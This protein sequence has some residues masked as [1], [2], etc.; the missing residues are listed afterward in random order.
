MVLR[1]VHLLSFKKGQFRRNREVNSIPKP[2]L[3]CG[4]KQLWKM[5][6]LEKLFDMSLANSKILVLKIPK[7]TKFG[8][9]GSTLP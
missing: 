7:L 4:F 9:V 1:R 2:K 6:Q 5:S 3:Q 8:R